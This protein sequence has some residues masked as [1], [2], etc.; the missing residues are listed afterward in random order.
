M[1]A[2]ETTAVL[3]EAARIVPREPLRERPSGEFRIIL[4]I[5]DADAQPAPALEENKDGLLALATHAEPMGALSNQEIDR[6][7]YGS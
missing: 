7:V 5:E 3:D 4:L 2:I 1:K 6:L